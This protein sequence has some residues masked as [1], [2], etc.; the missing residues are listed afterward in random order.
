MFSVVARLV[1]TAKELAVAGWFGRR[2]EVDAFLIAFLAPSIIVNLLAGSLNAALIP[3]FVQVWERE[4]REAAQRLLSNVTVC[5]LVLL[6]G[7]TVLM[8]GL[9][10][11]YVPLLG[12]GFSS[13][14][15][16]LTRHLV[17]VLMPFVVLGGLEVNW[18]AILNARERFALPALLPALSPVV[19]VLFLFSAGR[20]WG[21]Y[22]LAGGIVGGQAIETAMLAQAV[23]LS[24]LRLS[25]GWHGMDPATRQVV[26][27]YLPMLAGS[28]LMTSTT[29]VDQVMA[30]MLAGGSVAAL[31]YATKVVSA[32]L[33]IGSVALS[34]ALLP[35]FS[36]MTA[37][38]DW[39]ACRHTLGTYSRLILL[40][41]LPLTAALILLSQPLVRILFER[42][43]FTAADTDVVS[44]VQ[45]FLALQIPFYALGVMGVRLISAL[46]KNYLLMVVAALNT[47]LNLIL[48]YILMKFMG[49]AGIALST[50]M[51]YVASFGMVF[52]SVFAILPKPKALVT[53]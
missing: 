1:S 11:Y 41:T 3:T 6:A 36:R 14:K 49:V 39:A 44:R 47:L 52:A 8:G 33:S 28:L 53:A 34:T 35:Y 21:I 51:V 16:L 31:N 17:Y 32:I 9:A 7:I 13:D 18:I 5:S 2:P 45:T 4:G 37:D 29:L 38:E 12:S 15:L 30:A 48:N 27:Q 50:S 43:A 40:L 22:A 25:L 23:R 26:R 42:G 46:Q 24:G 10:R 20:V 19:V